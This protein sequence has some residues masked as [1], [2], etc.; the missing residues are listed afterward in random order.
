VQHPKFLELREDTARAFMDFAFEWGSYYNPN[1]T[2]LQSWNNQWKD[3]I[4]SWAGPL[5]WRAPLPPTAK[6]FD[7]PDIFSFDVKGPDGNMID[8]QFNVLSADLPRNA[9][10]MN[11][12]PL[13]VVD[14]DTITIDKFKPV[15]L[16]LRVIGIMA[17]EL[18]HPNE[19]IASEALRQQIFLEELVDISSDRLYYVPDVRFG[20]DAGKDSYG[21]ELGWLFVEGGIDGNMPAGTGQYIYFEE[22][23]QPTDRYYRR[24]DELGP[25]SDIIVPDYN[26]W[27][28]QTERY[29]LN[30]D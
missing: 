20:N 7:E 17:N 27:D 22:H 29:I 23:F 2:N 30:E 12:S 26:E 25:F 10:T 11:V 6:D 8:F 5:E 4:E 3:N 28:P 14:G 1:D 16:R 9:R 24:G 19:D 15:P 21:R 13:D 18:N